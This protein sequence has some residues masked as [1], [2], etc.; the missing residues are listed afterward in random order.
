MVGANGSNGT[1]A[2]GQTCGIAI[3]AKASAPGRTKTRLVPPLTF[4]EAAAINTAFLQDIA[5]N[6]LLAGCH[7]GIAGYAAF[8]PTGSEEFFS[9]ILPPAIGLI[10]ACLPNF[11]DCLLRTIE[12]IIERGHGSAVVLNSDSPTLP[13]AFLVETAR[14]LA[15]PGD[16][17]VLGPSSDG[18]YYLLGLKTAHRRMFEDI[19]WSTER[20]AQQ[21]LERAREIKLDVHMLP[22]WY[23]V[24]DVDG[25]RRLGG[26]L[27]R[28][29]ASRPRL[30]SRAPNYPAAT[31]ELFQSLW[32]D[33]EFSR[34]RETLMHA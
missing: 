26:E 22:V 32:P 23:D 28:P 11:G 8:A 12:E 14:V 9:R 17:A 6:L 31:A 24:D 27:H 5:G 1:S 25:L 13:T 29:R 21:T 2:T 3:M 4:D 7:A 34:R 10:D 30:D 15:R 19:A 20:V 33:G 18:G 16:R